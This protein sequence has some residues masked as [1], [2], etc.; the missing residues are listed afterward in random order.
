VID[1]ATG[2]A[3]VQLPDL[4]PPVNLVFPWQHPFFR[5]TICMGAVADRI[6]NGVEY[7]EREVLPIYANPAHTGWCSVLQPFTAQQL[8]IQLHK[9][10]ELDDHKT[11]IL[12]A[13]IE[14]GTPVAPGRTEPVKW[15]GCAKVIAVG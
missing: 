9:P 5:F 10:E 11:V 12:A 1:R 6:H 3:T 2:I 7:H 13:G 14:M 4:L 8:T 15:T